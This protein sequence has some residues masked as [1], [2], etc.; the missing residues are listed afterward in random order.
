MRRLPKAGLDV[1]ADR[2][3]LRRMYGPIPSI[4]PTIQKSRRPTALSM[5]PSNKGDCNV[6]DSSSAFI[7][8]LSVPINIITGM[9]IVL[10]IEQT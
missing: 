4:E 6:L 1:S 8:T 10:V 7:A 2:P 3:H 5:R 9:A